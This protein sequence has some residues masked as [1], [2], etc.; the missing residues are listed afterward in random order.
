MELTVNE[1]EAYL[2]RGP[3]EKRRKRN[4]KGCL[5]E[6]QEQTHQFHI[7]FTR[8]GYNTGQREQRNIHS[9]LTKTLS[10]SNRFKV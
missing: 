8:Q 7:H 2:V 9:T 10:I 4:G 1:A 6:I 3:V 5:Y